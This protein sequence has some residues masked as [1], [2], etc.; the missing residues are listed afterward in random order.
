MFFSKRRRSAGPL[1]CLAQPE[2]QSASDCFLLGW[3]SRVLF[4]SPSH[5]ANQNLNIYVATW[6]TT[7]PIHAMGLAHNYFLFE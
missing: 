5:L 7:G 2:C 6:S 4:V 1:S 3:L